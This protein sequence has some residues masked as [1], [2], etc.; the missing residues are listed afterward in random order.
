MK[1]FLC[2]IFTQKTSSSF[3]DDVKDIDTENFKIFTPKHVKF[4][5]YTD[6]DNVSSVKNDEVRLKARIYLQ[7][8]DD[9]EVFPGQK[10]EIFSNDSEF[11]IS[12]YCDFGKI[13][14]KNHLS[15]FSE[16]F[17]DVSVHSGRG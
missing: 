17:F 16:T 7:N 4:L 3:F 14:R 2:K 6:D 15:R 9:I 13:F 1:M 11:S 10:I 12:G 8:F 5:A